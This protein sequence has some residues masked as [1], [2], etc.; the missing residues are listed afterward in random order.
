MLKRDHHNFRFSLIRRQNGAVLLIL[1]AMILIAV[2]AVIVSQLSL[3]AQSIN[4]AK[5][6]TLALS[7]SKNILLGYALIQP[8]PGTLPCPD[9]NNDG[10]SDPT[11]CTNRRGLLPYKTLGIARQVDGTGQLLWYVVDTSYAG[12]IATPHNSSRLASLRIDSGSPLAFI[13]I[14]SNS[15]LPGQ[16]PDLTLLNATQ[17]LEGDNSDATLNSY[18]S[19]K[20]DTHNDLLL[21]VSTFD[22]WSPIEQMVLDEVESLI[23][24]YRTDCGMYPWAA[25][26]S[27]G[28]GI[29]I[30]DRYEGAFPLA[31]ASWGSGCATGIVPAGWLSTHWSGQLYYSIC[32]QPLS[33][34]PT[35]SC[36]SFAGSTQTAQVVVVAP[37]A[38]RDGLFRDNFLNLN[39]FFENEDAVANDRL[40]DLLTPGANDNDLL[41]F[42]E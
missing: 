19:L 9:S 38:T 39:N 28:D 20:D 37:G 26:F 16:S 24:R 42:F 29:R 2:T 11:G 7:Y 18:S 34:P 31:P 17:F 32:N 21:G 6:T 14:A 15:P 22:F 4:R 30:I 1:L 8:V 40:F 10:L 25:D 5:N 41:L 23:D 13:L 12:S 33:N 36:L 3:N 35:S 27:L